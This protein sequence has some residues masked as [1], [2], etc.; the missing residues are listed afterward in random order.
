MQKRADQKAPA[1]STG[2]R[3]RN[4]SAALCG[5]VGRCILLLVILACLPVPAARLC[6]YE[7][8]NVVSG[9]MEPAIPVGSAVFVRAAPPAQMAV[10]DVIAF[11][12]RGGT[13]ITHRVVENDTDAGSIV[14]KGDANAQPDADTVAYNAVIGRI[15]RHVPGLGWLLSIYTGG[16]GRVYLIC[17][18]AGGAVLSLLSVF[19]K[20]DVA[21][22]AEEQTQQAEESGEQEPV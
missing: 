2:R 17:F 5:I 7:I 1:H 14:T 9:S 19:L 11:H 6:G 10:G 4:L 22:K 21:E 15:E 12:A 18:A 8:F 13:V 16:S 3:G 20:R